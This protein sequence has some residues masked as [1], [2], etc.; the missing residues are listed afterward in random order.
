MVK[1]K[2]NNGFSLR[3]SQSMSQIA[4][5]IALMSIIPMLSLFALSMQSGRSVLPDRLGIVSLVTML[6]ALLLG[7]M[8][9]YLILIRQ[10]NS[11]TRLSRLIKLLENGEPP[12]KADLAATTEDFRLIENGMNMVLSQF[13]TDAAKIY[14][15]ADLI[16]KVLNEYNNTLQSISFVASLA[17]LDDPE[18]GERAQQRFQ[19][20]QS[21]ILEG[22]KKIDN[23]LEECNVS[24]LCPR[25]SEKTSRKLSK[26]KSE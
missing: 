23:L 19:D 18:P 9:G 15:R 2:N 22:R 17:L 13:S 7:A 24:A 11:V 8:G 25:D 26:P 16:S 1:N 21:T 14:A 20:V 6:V 4:V 5:A 10:E 12:S 3:N